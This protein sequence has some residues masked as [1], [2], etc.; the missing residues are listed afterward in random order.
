MLFEVVADGIDIGSRPSIHIHWLNRLLLDQQFEALGSAIVATR[1]YMPSG[2][3]ERHW[4]RLI[5][6]MLGCRHKRPIRMLGRHQLEF[7]VLLESQSNRHSIISVV[8]LNS[9]ATGQIAS[10]VGYFP[11]GMPTRKKIR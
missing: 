10:L 7:N 5:P 6:N 3:G 9:I 1:P 2:L 4:E 11:R 8:W